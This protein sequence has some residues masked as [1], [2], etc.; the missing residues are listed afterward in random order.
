MPANTA[1][2]PVALPS[3]PVSA[4]AAVAA[5]PVGLPRRSGCCSARALA[6]RLVA[7]PDADRWHERDAAPR[8]DRDLRRLHGGLLAGR[9]G[10]RVPLSDSARRHLRRRHAALR[11]RARRRPAALPPL[12]K[13]AAQVAAAAIV[14]ATGTDVQLVHN[15]SSRSRSAVLWLVG[16][17]NAFNLLDNMDGLA[18]TLAAIAFV[19]FAIDAVT[20]HPSDAAS[21]S[22]SPA[23]R[24]CLGF[25]P[26]NLRPRGNGARLHGRLRLADARLRPRGARPR[27]RAGTSPARRSRRFLLPILVL[28]VP[29]LDTTLVTIVRLLEGRP[30]SQGGR[31]HSLAP[32]RP[33]RP[34]REE[35]G[36]PARADRDRA[37]RHEPGLQRARRSAAGCRRR[38]S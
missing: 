20:I 3:P 21:R 16:M 37:R 11:R 7:A 17:T 36:R 22:R 5:L 8:R 25:L 38:R 26:F 15:K 24:A 29:I 14:L 18:A 12:A 4:V 31:D 33:L 27:R 9:R 23:R 6:R 35:R 10:W 13:L 28:A 32:A 34:L 1:L 19:F 2:T 30:I